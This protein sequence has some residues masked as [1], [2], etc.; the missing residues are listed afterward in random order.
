MT[1]KAMLL[2]AISI[3]AFSCSNSLETQDA[4]LLIQVNAREQRLPWPPD[5]SGREVT[6][7]NALDDP[8]AVSAGSTAGVHVGR[9][10]QEESALRLVVVLAQLAVPDR[11]R[12][13]ELRVRGAV[14][15]ASPRPP[16]RVRGRL[17]SGAWAL[18]KFRERL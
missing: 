1:S 2:I 18:S 10:Q 3:A 7:V 16:R 17:L 11:G 6:L 13:G 15:L 12:C 8:R 14:A 5:D 9:P 4:T